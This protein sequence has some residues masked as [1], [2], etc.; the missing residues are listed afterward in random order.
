M[1]RFGNLTLLQPPILAQFPNLLW[2]EQAFFFS[3]S[4]KDPLMGFVAHQHCTTRVAPT[5]WQVRNF[6]CVCPPVVLDGRSVFDRS[7]P[8]IFLPACRAPPWEWS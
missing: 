3:K 2:L 6:N 8:Y 1:N 5:D 4:P 7:G